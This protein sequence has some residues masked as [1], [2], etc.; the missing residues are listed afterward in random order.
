M[1]PSRSRL[2]LTGLGSNQDLNSSNGDLYYNSRPEG[3]WSYQPPPPPVITQQPKPSTTQH[4]QPYE[5]GYPKTLESLAEKVSALCCPRGLSFSRRWFI[6]SGIFCTVSRTHSNGN[7]WVYEK[8]R[9][10]SG[11]ETVTN[12]IVRSVILN[13]SVIATVLIFTNSLKQ[14][15]MENFWAGSEVGFRFHALFKILS[16]V[17]MHAQ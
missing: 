1:L 7:L 15:Q 10:E 16:C 8:S 12:Y 5:R 2:G 4:F 6:D 9:K 11:N 14:Q 13:Y 3:H 17:E